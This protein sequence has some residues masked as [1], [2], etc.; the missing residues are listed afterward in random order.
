MA[1]RLS[2]HTLARIDQNNGKIGCGSACNHVARILL[3]ARRIGNDELAL[4][5]GEVTIGDINGN[6]LFALRLQAV[7]KQRQI[8]SLPSPACVKYG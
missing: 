5:G 2:E 1:A 6:A 7:G 4:G 8:D 3:V